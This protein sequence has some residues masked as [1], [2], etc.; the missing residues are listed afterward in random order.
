MLLKTE[1][2]KIDIAT[3]GTSRIVVDKIWHFLYGLHELGNPER[4]TLAL[5]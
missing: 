1:I 5:R 4:V 2:P 3:S